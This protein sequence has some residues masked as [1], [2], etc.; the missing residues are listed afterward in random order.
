MKWIGVFILCA[1][2]ASFSAS[3][4]VF[5]TVLHSAT[6]GPWQVL[7]FKDAFLNKPRCGIKARVEV[8]DLEPVSVVVSRG[9][10]SNKLAGF[11]FDGLE[12]TEIL[13]RTDGNPS[14]TFKCCA[15]GERVL[16]EWRNGKLVALRFFYSGGANRDVA[17]DLTKF[18]AALK[19]F[20]EACRKFQ[21][22]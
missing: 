14:Q 1:I 16:R 9:T 13:S 15:V 5:H 6:F 7:C 20:D 18:D 3:A 19:D 11:H 2:L 17:L 22:C 8:A 10:S 12:P 21:D 4:Q